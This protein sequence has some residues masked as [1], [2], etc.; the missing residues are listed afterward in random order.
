M[1]AGLIVS[2]MLQLAFQATA[3]SW[4]QRHIVSGRFLSGLNFLIEIKILLA[5]QTSLSGR[6]S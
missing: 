4:R 6:K 3:N 1:F 5:Y 2:A